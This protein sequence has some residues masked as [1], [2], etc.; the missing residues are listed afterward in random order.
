MC[1]LPHDGLCGGRIM[2]QGCDSWL[3]CVDSTNG[4]V[5][6]VASVGGTIGWDVGWC[7]C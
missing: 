5:T 7:G 1:D 4:S 2:T 3:N 6:C